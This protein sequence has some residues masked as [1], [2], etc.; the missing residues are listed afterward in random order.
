MLVFHFAQGRSIIIKEKD[1]AMLKIL[2]CGRSN[3][4]DMSGCL[5]YKRN[6]ENAG[7]AAVHVE[8]MD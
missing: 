7:C 3:L 5:F 2:V 6:V 8:C 4:V 1:L